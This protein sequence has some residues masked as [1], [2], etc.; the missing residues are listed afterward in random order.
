[1]DGFLSVL[2][3]FVCSHLQ[4]I[5]ERLLGNDAICLFE[6]VNR[7]ESDLVEL[8]HASSTITRSQAKSIIK[9]HA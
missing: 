4:G 6:T 9:Q 7:I 1:M 3:K 5:D 2:V 8:S